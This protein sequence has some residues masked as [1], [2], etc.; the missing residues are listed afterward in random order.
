MSNLR[1]CYRCHCEK[2]LSEFIR[3]NRNKTGFG[4]ICKECKKVQDKEYY[5]KIK[6]DPEKWAHRLKLSR[7]EKARHRDRELNYNR[8]YNKKPEVIE[9]KSE[10][11][12]K[13]NTKSLH[14]VIYNKWRAAKQRSIDKQLPFDLTVEY[15][16][17]IYTETCPILEIPL[18]WKGGPR[19]DNTPALDKIIPSMGY[20]QGNVRFISTKANTMKTDATIEQLLTFAKNIKNYLQE[21]DIVRTTE[22]N[23]SVELK[24]KEPLG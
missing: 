13:R 3:D 6:A 15:L 1:I 23:E 12:R 5:E 10:W 21:K 16:E 17:S 11:A 24:D 8:N 22:N 7:E 18:N 9:R 2:E 20:V 4:H 14:R 19:M